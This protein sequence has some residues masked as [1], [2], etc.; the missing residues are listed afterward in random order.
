MHYSELMVSSSPGPQLRAAMQWL[1][2]HID[3]ER[4]S[5]A[6]RQRTVASMAKRMEYM[7]KFLD[8]LDN[9]QRLYPS[10]HITG[11]NGKT[12]AARMITQLV[13]ANGLRAG[14]YT[15]PHLERFN[16]RIAI[17][18]EE[19]ADADLA[20]V[21]KSIELLEQLI[22]ESELPSYFEIMAA[23]AFRHFADAP[24][25]AAV[26][27]VGLGG[28]YDATNVLN[29][30]VAVI[31][32]IGEDHKE[33]LG[34]TRSEIARTKAGIIAEGATVVTGE[35]D[36]ELIAIFEECSPER[37]LVYGRDFDVTSNKL[38]V[39]GRLLNIRTS[40][41]TY[42]NVFV[43]VRGAHQ[44]IN[45]AVSLAAAEAFF[46]RS[47]AEDVVASGFGTVTTPGRIEVV[48]RNPL[49]VI[50]GAHNVEAAQRLVEALDEEFSANSGR[51]YVVGVLNPHDPVEIL[52]ALGAS[53]ARLVVAC[54]APSPRAVSAQDIAAAARKLGAPAVAVD[55]CAEA[56]EE[57]RK[58]AT[59]DDVVVVTGSLYVVGAARSVLVNASSAS[60]DEDEAEEDQEDEAEEA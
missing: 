29:A 56:V 3:F 44:G 10:I 43:P 47:L 25:D 54:T 39:G 18:G 31:T 7:R 24:V 11:T 5:D 8:V 51:L 59:Q 46:Q 40:Y 55:D 20:E 57:A 32:N 38:A 22:P 36:P 2:S 60:G 1:D 17:D 34:D 12:S 21:L 19:I 13:Q 42:E 15:S 33:L 35:T 30:Q 27:E 14:T 58:A 28:T 37:V 41:A 4:S 50:D 23:A 16:E 26:V 49:T 6:K 48:D 53:S 9:P 45:A 52:Q